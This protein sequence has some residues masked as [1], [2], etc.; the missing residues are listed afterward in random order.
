[1]VEEFFILH[2]SFRRLERS[3]KFKQTFSNGEKSAKLV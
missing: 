3:S 1:L 2:Q